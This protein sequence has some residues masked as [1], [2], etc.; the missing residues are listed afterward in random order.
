[1]KLT[2]PKKEEGMEMLPSTKNHTILT[3]I[4]VIFALLCLAWLIGN[5]TELVNPGSWVARNNMPNAPQGGWPKEILVYFK[6]SMVASILFPILFCFVTLFGLIKR[7]FFSLI[8]G[9][10][11]LATG[12]FTNLIF[13]VVTIK[14]GSIDLYFLFKFAIILVIELAALAYLIIYTVECFKKTKI[15]V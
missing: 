10:I 2:K 6:I 9:Y 7:H 11:S 14:C 8:T 5:V 3:T 15:T 12:M 4:W 13:N 1:M